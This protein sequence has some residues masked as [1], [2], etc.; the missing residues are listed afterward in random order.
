MTSY[1]KQVPAVARA[2]DLLEALGS[3]P[4][5]MGAADLGDL[6][7]G[8]RSGLFALLNTLKGRGWVEQH[9]DGRYR[10][11]VGL[12]RLDPGPGVDDRG[13]RRAWQAAVDDLDP[14]EDLA[15]VRPDGAE[16]VV[17]ATRDGRHRVRCLHRVGE[18]RRGPGADAAVLRADDAST[19]DAM[20]HDLGVARLVTDDIV[21]VAAPVCRDGRTP[22]AA[23]LVVVPRQRTTPGLVQ[24]VTLLVRDLARDVSRRL[25]APDWQPG[26]G[27]RAVGPRRVLGDDE[28]AALLDSR[29]HAQLACLRDDGS[30]HVVPLWFWWDGSMLWLTASPGSAWSD[31]VGRGSRV[32]LTIEERH[33]DLRRVFV[34]GWA[35]PVPD[36]EVDAV[37]PGGVA[38]LR[39]SLWER[40][41]GAGPVEEPTG[42]SAV[43]VRPERVHGLAGLTGRAA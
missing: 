3:T 12:R 26:V 43:R 39:A 31:Y 37:V 33:P 18:D 28:V 15:L 23:V 34:S 20:T 22:D 29:Q 2:V 32:S 10:I 1:D 11:G 21:E 40:Y 5:G 42:W 13:L 17:L 41:V 35:E 8:S 19:T 14:G 9:P 25:G 38:A 27:H 24:G 7:D 30:P 4:D 16:R 36:A 6:V